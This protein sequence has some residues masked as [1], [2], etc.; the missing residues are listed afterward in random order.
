M[1]YAK[2]IIWV[3]RMIVPVLSWDA[4]LNMTKV[5]LEVI[6]DA[7]MYLLLEKGTRGTASYI[8]KRYSKAINKYWKCYHPNEKSKHITYIDANNLWDVQSS[9]NNQICMDRSKWFWL[10]YVYQQYFK[11]LSILKNY[12]NCM[13]IL[14]L[15]IK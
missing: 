11:W 4:M 13:I 8:F 1:D 15:Q 2:V 14:W 6:L 10:K 5:E 7:D 12:V 9:F 3:Q